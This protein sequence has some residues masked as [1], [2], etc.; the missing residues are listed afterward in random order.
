MKYILITL[1]FLL[2]S[3]KSF[4]VKEDQFVIVHPDPAPKLTLQNPEWRVV[5]QQQ[6]QALAND[7]TKRDS[8]WYLLDESQ[9]MLLMDNLVQI[10]DKT[11]KQDLNLM[12]YKDSIDKYNQT[13]GKNK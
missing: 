6:M 5:N 8:I 3:C 7:P 13:K 4:T 12:F 1:I 11:K 9:F 10:S 2:A